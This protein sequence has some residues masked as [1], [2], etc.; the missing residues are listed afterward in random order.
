MGRAKP[1][2]VDHGHEDI[3]TVKHRLLERDDLRARAI[4]A[5]LVG[6]E[7]A[8]WGHDG[9]HD[10]YWCCYCP[11]QG[12]AT[13]NAAVARSHDPDCPIARARILLAGTPYL[14]AESA[15]GEA[16]EHVDRPG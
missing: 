2:Y 11:V 6:N 5:E 3:P 14:P 1:S 7:W 13:N 16:Q 4:L 9:A 15:P 10:E 8:G 12:A